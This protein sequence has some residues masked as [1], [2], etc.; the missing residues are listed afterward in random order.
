MNSCSVRTHHLPLC[1]QFIGVLGRL[2]P[3]E[4]VGEIIYG[5]TI[6]SREYVIASCFLPVRDVDMDFD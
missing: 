1:G 2:H 6:D 3:A 4:Y 5:S